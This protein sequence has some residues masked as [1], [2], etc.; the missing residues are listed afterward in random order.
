MG[1][2]DTIGR[3]ARPFGAAD[4]DD[5]WLTALAGDSGR[6]F[7][8]LG[9][10][11]HGT[12]EFYAERARITLRLVREFG[13]QGVAGE[14]D[15]PDAARLDRY[16]RGGS[17]DRTAEESLTDF[18]R[19]PRW[20]WRNADM[21]DFLRSLR[22]SNAVSDVPAG[23]WGVDLYS[24][25]SS[26]RAVLRWLDREHPEVAP[27]VR[28][29]YARLEPHE[30]APARYGLHVATGTARASAEGVLEALD[31]VRAVTT[32]ADEGFDALRNAR[33][34]VAAEA[35]YRGMY[36]PAVS[37]WN[38][39]DR[40]MADTV[41]AIAGWLERRTGRPARLV[42]WAHNSHVGDARAAEMGEHGETS[43]GALLR[44]RHGRAVVRTVGFTT[45]RGTVTAA[46][47][48]DSP[49]ERR[50]LRE[51]PPDGWESLLHALG[52]PRVRIDCDALTEPI[53][54]RAERAVG[55]LYLP[56]SER[57]SHCFTSQLACRYDH[58]L[59][60]DDTTAVEPLD[61]RPGVPAE[62]APDTY[63][64]GV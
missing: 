6:R 54:A 30:E 12:H 60:Y 15:W 16:L 49:A 1:D 46:R 11:T 62:D 28:A 32:D 8:L 3:A 58:V 7:V 52:E 22:A 37:T 39:R 64:S 61:E 26:M 13:F 21:R 42:V 56:D 50:T 47:A 43:L 31:R 41:E 17:A 45:W 23:F 18:R 36:Q 40:H 4:E 9:E 33:L 48:W 38:L 27:D 57:Q 59:H 25:H 53:A 55:V 19:F 5:A 44:E 2:I 51:G 35:Y 63:P 14:A 34:V 10:M 29:A 24:L 20:M